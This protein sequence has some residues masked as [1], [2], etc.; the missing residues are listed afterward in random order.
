MATTPLPRSQAQLQLAYVDRPE[1]LETYVDSLWRVYFDG[2]TIRMDFAVHR[3]DDPQPQV[4]PTGKAFTAARIVMPVAAMV[5]M[6]NKLQD[7]VAQL[8][9][10]GTLRHVHA[11]AGTQMPH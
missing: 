1:I 5:N 4:P 8:Q 2:Q 3:L 11:P 10:Q 7:V 9:A 6:L